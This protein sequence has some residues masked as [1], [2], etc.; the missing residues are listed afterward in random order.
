MLGDMSI[1]ILLVEDDPVQ[2]EVLNLMLE[3]N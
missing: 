3:P 1:K 2:R